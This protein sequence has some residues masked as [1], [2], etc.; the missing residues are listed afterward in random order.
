VGNLGGNME[1]LNLFK[2]KKEIKKKKK[3][4]TQHMKYVSITFIGQNALF[5]IYFF[6]PSFSPREK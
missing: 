4:N 3:K 5:F 6:H 2:N 1:R